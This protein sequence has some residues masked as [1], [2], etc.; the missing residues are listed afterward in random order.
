M[1]RKEAI[2]LRRDPRSMILAFLL[3]LLLLLFFGYAIT[4]DVNNIPLAVLDQDGTAREPRAGGRVRAPPAT[5]R[6]A[7]RLDRTAE[8]DRCSTAASAAIVLVDPARTSPTT[9]ASGRPA[10]VQALVDGSDANTATIA[11]GY[12][13]GDRAALRRQRPPPAAPVRPPI[14]AEPRSGTTRSSRAAT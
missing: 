4:W 7:E 14:D 9:C 8:A 12:A 13:G 1:A 5:S 2:Q 10:P 11:L 3:P 6:S